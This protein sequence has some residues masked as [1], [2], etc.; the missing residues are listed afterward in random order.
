MKY[1]KFR[2][3]LCLVILVSLSACSGGSSKE[4]EFEAEAKLEDRPVGDLYNEA[5]DTLEAKNYKTAASMFD[6]VDRLYPYSKWAVK[7][8]VMSAYA[9]YEAGQY[10]D[11]IVAANRFI[12][13]H[14]GSEDAAYAYYL[15]AVSYYEQISDVARDQKITMLAL[16]A[17]DQL[18]A[19]FPNSNYAKDAKLKADLA[20]DH[21]AGKEMNIGRYYLRQGQY[22]AAINRFQNVVAGHQTTSHVPEALHRLVETYVSL[23][24]IDEAKKTAAILGHNYSGTKWYE[25]SYNLANGAVQK[26]MDEAS[27]Q[28]Q[29]TKAE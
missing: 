27:A 22:A 16:E 14:P 24:L 7:A 2:L 25:M 5:M 17:L 18:V 9:Y 8:Q 29:E 3:F 23:G 10:D 19:R 28:E 6:D 20:R 26:A 12:Q 4:K 11:A 21:L 15:R 1:K 13:L